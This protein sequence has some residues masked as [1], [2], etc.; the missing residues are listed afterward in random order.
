M[1]SSFAP[2][3]ID[4]EDDLIPDGEESIEIIAGPGIAITTKATASGIGT[5]LSKALTISATGSGG[6]SYTDLSVTQNAAGTASLSYNNT[7]GAFTYTPPDIS[8]KVELTDFSVGT[9]GT[10]LGSGSLNYNNSTGVFTYTPPDL[11]SYLTTLGS[12]DGHTDVDTTTT[13]PTDGQLLT[14]NNATSSWKPA[15]APVSGIQLGDISVTQ[16]AAGTAA[17]SYSANTGVF[18]YT[19][20]DLSNISATVSASDLNGISIDAL[21]DVDT[22]TASP[23]NG[24]GL[25][26]NDTAQQWQPQNITAT[27]APT[28][29]DYGETFPTTGLSEGDLFYNSTY[30]KIFIRF[31]GFWVDAA[32]NLASPVLWDAVD[33]H[34]LPAVDNTYDLG[35]FSKRWRNI[36]TTDLNLS[37]EGKQNDVDGS[38]GKWTIQE[39]EDDLFIINRRNGKK[40]KFTLQEVD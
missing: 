37:N 26:W 2:W 38:W 21:S 39:G 31:D 12:I 27:A 15:N 1:G 7:T 34:L 36:Y 20:P 30:G 18:T 16:T 8:G 28:F 29:V 6:I 9:P 4:G 35:S 24:Q 11:S 40:Y 22:T 33:D 25:I 32:P 17:L 10:P 13:P 19:P 5:G 14:W 23:S 3:Y